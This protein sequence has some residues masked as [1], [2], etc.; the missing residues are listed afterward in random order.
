MSLLKSLLIAISTFS[1]IPVP[2]F[3]WD[4]KSTKY[5]I[6][7]FPVVGIFI[8]LALW[9]LY[10]LMAVN[11]YNSLLFAILATVLPVLITGGIHMDGF[12]DTVD[13]LASRQSR[14]RKLE[15]LKDP[16]VGA[17]AII[18]SIVYFLLY[19][20]LV[21]QL[22]FLGQIRLIL[23]PFILSRALSGLSA[24]TMPNAR[25]SGMLYSFTRDT[26]KTVS[27]LLLIGALVSSTLL[28]LYLSPANGIVAILFAIVTFFLY[29]NMAKRHFGGV[30]GDTS[31]FFVQICE[32]AFLAGALIGM[33]LS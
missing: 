21:Y 17:F 31:G 11:P 30:T 29:S 12:I 8:S 7:F 13:A 3:E 5:S 2:Q 14:E 25:Q 19:L 9:G 23:A 26:D 6:S 16:H 4:E 27:M 28:V 1:I 15:I 32:L 18:Y 10:R 22:L 24:I 20:G 33:Y